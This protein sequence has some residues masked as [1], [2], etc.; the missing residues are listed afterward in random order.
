MQPKECR[1]YIAFILK[2]LQGTT[3]AIMSAFDALVSGSGLS[4]LADKAVKQ[5]NRIRHLIAQASSNQKGIGSRN[6]LFGAQK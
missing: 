3:K 6:V 1:S 5:I 4:C 2:N